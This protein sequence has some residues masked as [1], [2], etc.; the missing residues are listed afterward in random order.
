MECWNHC[1]GGDSQADIP[2]RGIDPLDLNANAVWW[3]GPKWLIS[4]GRPEVQNKLGDELLPEQCLTEMKASDRR[5]A[6][7]DD[8]SALTVN[9]ESNSLSSVIPCDSFSS[10]ERLLR[11]TALVMKFI[12]LLKAKHSGTRMR[13]Q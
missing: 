10:L 11:V 4:S 7:S 12:K 8:L 3:S 2:F 1:P 5:A 6:H 13:S 9:N